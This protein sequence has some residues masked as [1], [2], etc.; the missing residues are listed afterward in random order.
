MRCAS[1]SASPGR[2]RDA[3]TVLL[4]GRRV[5]SCLVLAITLHDA[6]V[7]TIEGLGTV[8][9]PH[10]VQRGFLEHD[11]YQCGYCTPG[12]IC[13]AVGMLDEVARGWPSAVTITQIVATH[14]SRL[15]AAPLHTGRAHVQRRARRPYVAW[16]KPQHET[17]RK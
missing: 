16:G 9:E 15:D 14:R 3:T 6:H 7:T 17:S 4:D 10:L 1:I 5:N 12:Q 11:G 13:S 2:R 8:E